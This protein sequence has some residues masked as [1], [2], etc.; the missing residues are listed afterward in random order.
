[1]LIVRGASLEWKKPAL[2]RR[3]K[4][5]GWVLTESWIRSKPYQ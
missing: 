5:P 2:W 1:M 4:R 3:H